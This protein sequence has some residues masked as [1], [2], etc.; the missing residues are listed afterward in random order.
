MLVKDIWDRDSQNGVPH[1]LQIAIDTLAYGQNIPLRILDIN[2]LVN[3]DV[4]ISELIHNN[5]ANILI[6]QEILALR[7]LSSSDFE[8]TTKFLFDKTKLEQYSDWVLSLSNSTNDL[9]ISYNFDNDEHNLWKSVMLVLL[10]H[11]ERK[12]WL[13]AMGNP[14]PGHAISRMVEHWALYILCWMYRNA[15]QFKDPE[16]GANT[17]KGQPNALIHKVLGIENYTLLVSRSWRTS[18]VSEKKYK[19]VSGPFWQK[20]IIGS[21]QPNNEKNTFCS[22]DKSQDRHKRF[23]DKF[24]TFIIE[25]KK[26]Q[27][28]TD[29]YSKSPLDQ[30]IEDGFSSR[31]DL[32]NDE[33]QLR[34]KS[35]YRA[36]THYLL[37]SDVKINPVKDAP[38]S[39]ANW[40]TMAA[41]CCWLSRWD[42]LLKKI[43]CM[44]HPLSA[45]DDIKVLRIALDGHRVGLVIQPNTEAEWRVEF[46]DT[47]NSGLAFRS[48]FDDLRKKVQE[49]H[50]GINIDDPE[51]FF[52]RLRERQ[53]AAWTAQIVAINNLLSRQT[54][55][56]NDS[57]GSENGSTSHELGAD[58]IRDPTKPRLGS[59]VDEVGH[60][61]R[62]YAGR[63]CHH[64]IG[65]IRADV[66]DIYWLDYSQTPPR[67]IHAG[68]YANKLVHRVNRSKIHTLFD[69]WAWRDY[70]SENS[71]SCPAR[72][73]K[74]ESQAYRAAYSHKADVVPND[75]ANSNQN[76]YFDPYPEP[77]PQSGIGIPLLINGRSV[78]VLTFAGMH[79]KQFDDRVLI[80][81]RRAAQLIAQSLYQSSLLWHMRQLNWSSTHTP[82]FHWKK[83]DA[84]N[85]FNPLRQISECLTNVF[86]CRAV[87]I[88]LQHKSRRT[89]YELFGYNHIA[90]FNHSEISQ[91]TST[92]TSLEIAPSFDWEHRN[93]EHSGMQKLTRAY[94]CFALD[95]SLSSKEDLGHFTVARYVADH[96][97]TEYTST[98]ASKGMW[99]HDD[100][101][102]VVGNYSESHGSYRKSIFKTH[103]LN[104]MLA[105][106][107]LQDKD[108]SSYGH[109]PIGVLTL[110]DTNS[111]IDSES[112]NYELPPQ[113]WS[114]AWAPTV[115]HIQTYL[116]YL[117]T[118]V[119]LLS[120]P[121]E[122]IRQFL[123]HSV[124]S[125]L[126]VIRSNMTAINDTAPETFKPNGIVRRYL[127]EIRQS[128]T[129]NTI[130]ADIKIKDEIQHKIYAIENHIGKSYQTMQNLMDRETEASIQ[131]LILLIEK[132]KDLAQIGIARSDDATD[133]DL[134]KFLQ[135]KVNELFDKFKS[136]GVDPKVNPFNRPI[137]IHIDYLWWDQLVSNLIEN[138]AKYAVERY[139]ITWK[140]S[141]KCLIFSNTGHF[142]GSKDIRDELLAQGVRGSA[143]RNTKEDGLGLGLWG[144]NLLC[145]ILNIEFS[146]DIYPQSA[147]LKNAQPLAEYRFTLKLPSTILI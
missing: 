112:L 119:E 101:I 51:M 103:G 71:I 106:V 134:E 93:N 58:D 117:L 9:S 126:T 100:F 10:P 73:R 96:A 65:M 7:N 70:A 1:G 123:I 116:P 79:T 28:W 122:N 84:E 91:H 48:N 107:L 4:V 85:G 20:S 41:L 87:H 59:K 81:L 8:T 34:T 69:E 31:V 42:A 12:I 56:I 38:I 83:H 46:V 64:L 61:L 68:G 140:H 128:I 45:T 24:N 136:N 139:E 114:T 40:E 6:R 22:S 141:N 26:Q 124:K 21:T 3:L 88:W 11:I 29:A 109:Q 32:T 105:C 23:I 138:A 80:P 125:N 135:K 66:A 86:L 36:L 113:P 121:L 47:N 92:S 67:L 115:A 13:S 49:I 76:A 108:S 2:N 57:S 35:A 99:L 147:T 104:D 75:D 95:K 25:A 146:F 102:E 130:T 33:A 89:H 145:K 50:D 16:L 132:Q 52:N 18:E 90:V 142:D 53:N 60:L 129:S 14:L 39:R 133:H 43:C 55:K 62:G 94:A 74:S 137:F 118:Q 144:V 5:D 17:L 44:S 27:H 82:Y 143:A 111:N 72:Q 120:S 97:N 15:D 63:I 30:E 110:H 77:K 54:P 98:Q 131:R 19:L 37:K 78:G 127:S